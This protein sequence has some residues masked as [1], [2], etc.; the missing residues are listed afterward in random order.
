[1]F[2]VLLT[3]AAL[4]CGSTAKPPSPE[5]LAFKKEISGTLGKLQQSLS[6][7]IAKG[8]V[9]A[10][11]A[12]L[13]DLS[14]KTADICV[15]CPYKTAVLDRG[16]T[17]ITT[18]PDNEVIGRNFS[19]YKMVKEPLQK[20]KITQSRAYSASGAKMYFISAPLIV[21]GKVA[22]V[23][24]LGLTPKDIEKWRLEEKEFLSLDLNAPDNH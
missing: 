7:P 18:F 10:I 16:G 6:E 1:M 3:L 13:K 17:L 21:D 20:Q 23:V 15:D 11:N 24:V 2:M 19:S 4:G 22:G 8:N 9:A 5:G 14:T 12:I